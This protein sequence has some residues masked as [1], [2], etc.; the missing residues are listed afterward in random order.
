M[1][2]FS[3]SSLITIK[4]CYQMKIPLFFQKIFI[5]NNIPRNFS[6]EKQSLKICSGWNTFNFE[7]Y[8]SKHIISQ[9]G[10]GLGGGHSGSQQYFELMAT[11]PDNVAKITSNVPITA[12]NFIFFSWFLL[13]GFNHLNELFLL[14][15]YSFIGYIWTKRNSIPLVDSLCASAR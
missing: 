4:C 3:K 13:N 8:L 5:N 7:N 2:V 12:I 10:S 6:F 1:I 14:T 15:F 9:C 11:A